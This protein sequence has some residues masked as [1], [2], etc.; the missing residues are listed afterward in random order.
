MHLMNLILATCWARSLLAEL[1][2]IIKICKLYI[3]LRIFYVQTLLFWLAMPN[4]LNDK[5]MTNIIEIRFYINPPLCTLWHHDISHDDST[6]NIVVVIIIII[7]IN[8][9]LIDLIYTASGN[10]AFLC[11]ITSCR[12]FQFCKNRFRLLYT[13]MLHLH[14]QN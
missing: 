8:S 1:K 6:I 14:L 12:Q 7:I 11:Y 13:K 4:V 5:S 9:V 3:H 2:L 10:K